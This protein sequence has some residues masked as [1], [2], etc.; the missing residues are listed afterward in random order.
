MTLGF[1]GT[2]TISAA[3]VHGLQSAKS[4][5][6]IVVSPRNVEIARGL[7]ERYRK[8]RVASSN[9][10][11]VDESD[12]VVLAIRPQIAHEV[13]TSLKWGPHHHIISLIPAVSLKYLQSVTAPSAGVT[14]AVP[15]PS[16]TYRQAPT[17]IYPPTPAVKEIFDQVGTA[18][19]LE[20]EDEFDAFTTATAT[21]SSYFGFAATITS[22]L[23]RQNISYDKAHIYVGQMLRGLSA[24]T[25]AMPDLTFD[26]LAEEHQTRGGLNEQVFNAITTDRK[27]VELQRAMDGVLQ[28]LIA[29]KAAR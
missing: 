6:D 14:R 7:A 9:Q 18:I 13:I 5:V 17:V 24:A 27:F 26:K 15:L 28:R 4:D 22:W 25:L 1:V 12:T 21:L 23:V 20:S 10:Q 11:V 3:V 16:A 19:P 8:V 2:G 29:G